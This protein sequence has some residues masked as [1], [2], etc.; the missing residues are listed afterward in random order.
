MNV[1]ELRAAALFEV[2]DEVYLYGSTRWTVI[3]RYWSKR[4]GCIVYDI[5]FPRTDVT[6]RR[7][8]ED[9]LSLAERRR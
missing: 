4:Q 8:A 2:G 3:A 9:R 6:S 5:H 1:E 7:I